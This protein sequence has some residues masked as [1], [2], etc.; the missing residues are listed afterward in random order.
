METMTALFWKIIYDNEMKS[1]WE[2]RAQKRQK[3]Q[4]FR[5][6]KP[7]LWRKRTKT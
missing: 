1:R 7:A 2:K 4:T 6:T 5:L 3:R